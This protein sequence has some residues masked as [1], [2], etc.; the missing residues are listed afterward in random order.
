MLGKY[1]HILFIV[2]SKT[3]GTDFKGWQKSP[4]KKYWR[5]K[6]LEISQNM[7]LSQLHEI[8]TISISNGTA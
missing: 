3:N 8:H 6:G 1:V 4:E 2:C 5:R 7:L